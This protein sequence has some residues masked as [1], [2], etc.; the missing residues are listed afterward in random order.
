MFHFSGWEPSQLALTKTP[1]CIGRQS[2]AQITHF[3]SGA[4]T[5]CMV[6]GLLIPNLLQNNILNPEAVLQDSLLLRTTAHPANSHECGLWTD[7]IHP[8][9]LTNYVMQKLNDKEVVSE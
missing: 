6:G 7:N 3:S 2:L 8:Y 1:V 4:K 5:D 9:Y